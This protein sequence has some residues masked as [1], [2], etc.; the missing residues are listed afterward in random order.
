VERTE[1]VER[2]QPLRQGNWYGKLKKTVGL[3]ANYQILF[4]IYSL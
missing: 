3:S 2:T 4:K 1:E